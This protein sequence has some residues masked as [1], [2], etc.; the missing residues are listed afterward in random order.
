MSSWRHA[1]STSDMDQL[2]CGLF[3]N[4]SSIFDRG[5]TFVNG[6]GPERVVGSMF[7]GKP[8]IPIWCSIM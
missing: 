3:L 5:R 2:P 1:T 4:L 8:T 7:R 6:G